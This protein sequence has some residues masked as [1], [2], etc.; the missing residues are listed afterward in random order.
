MADDLQLEILKQ[1][2]EVR[3]ELAQLRALNSVLLGRLTDKTHLSFEEIGQLLGIGKT[4]AWRRFKAHLEI[5]PG[6]NRRGVPLDKLGDGW[7]PAP[8]I[9]AARR[10]EK[11]LR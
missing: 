8:A 11:D 3:Q 7:V 2:V 5:I 9:S 1:V 6:T 4:S 10:R